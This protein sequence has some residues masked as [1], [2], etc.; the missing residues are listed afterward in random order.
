MSNFKPDEWLKFVLVSTIPITFILVLVMVAVRDRVLDPVI[1]GG[2]L[3]LLGGILAAVTVGT[4]KG[5]D[6]DEPEV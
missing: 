4:S 6:K 5:K 1:S 3:T 2:M